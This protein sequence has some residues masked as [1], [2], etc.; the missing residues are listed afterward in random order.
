MTLKLWYVWESPEKLHKN[1]ASQAFAYLICLIRSILYWL[2]RW[3]W[4]ILTFEN[5]QHAAMESKYGK[6]GKVDKMAIFPTHL[7]TACRTLLR[8]GLAEGK[9]SI[10]FQHVSHSFWADSFLIAV[11][12]PSDLS[13]RPMP[14]YIEQSE[15]MWPCT[16]TIGE[17]STDLF[18]NCVGVGLSTLNIQKTYRGNCFV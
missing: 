14:T 3:L 18:A 11:P 17:T 8:R 15:V 16:H 9:V 2:S 6:G 4:Y 12:S 13:E 5:H 1:A 7:P 10:L